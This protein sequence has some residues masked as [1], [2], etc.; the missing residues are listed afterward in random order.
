MQ[1]WTISIG[2]VVAINYL[3]NFFKFPFNNTYLLDDSNWKMD[4][5]YNLAHTHKWGCDFSHCSRHF[6]HTTQGKDQYTSDFGMLCLMDSQNFLCIQG[7]NW[8]ETQ[9]CQEGKNSHNDLRHFLEDLNTDHRGWDC[10][11][12]QQPQAQLLQKVW[13]CHLHSK[14]CMIHVNVLYNFA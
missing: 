6:Y 13:N 11:D 14:I 4:L 7:D 10:M 3:F 2:L 1:G 8:G 5:R 9:S 12:H